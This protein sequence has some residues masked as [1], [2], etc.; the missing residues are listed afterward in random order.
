MT[1][2]VSHAPATTG[3]RSRRSDLWRGVLRNKV[4]VI[5][6]AYLVLVILAAILAPWIAPHSP[7]QASL[8]YRSQPPSG[9][10]WFG[11]DEQGRDIL[12]R[13]LLARASRC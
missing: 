10:F 1:M 9:M 3:F 2:I 12:S 11:T 8:R 7:Y 6:T 5:C 4:A 13:C